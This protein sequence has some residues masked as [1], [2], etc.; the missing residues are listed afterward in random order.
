MAG[1][2][3]II[4]AYNLNP[5]RISS[6]LSFEIG[7][8][9][10]ARIVSA[11]DLGEGLILRLRDGWQFSAKLQSQLDFI[12]EGLV[13]FQVEDFQDGKLQLKIV[14]SKREDTAK[15]S[16]DNLLTSESLGVDKEDYEVLKKMIIHNMPLTKE[17]ISKVKTLIQFKSKIMQDNSS[18][19]GF[20]DSYLRS[21]DIDINSNEGKEME[22]RLRGFFKELKGINIDELLTMMEN[23]IDLTEEN[24]KSFLKTFKGEAVLYKK[25]IELDGIKEQNSLEDAF[26]IKDKLSDAVK[27]E[28]ESKIE[29]MKNIIKVLLNEK[30]KL[31]DNISDSTDFKIFNTI[32]NEYYLMDIPMNILDKKYNF[33]L[34]IK[35]ERSKGKKIDSKDVSLAVSLKTN[36]IGIVDAYIK[37]KDSNMHVN[38]KSEKSWFNALS[39]D[40]D[41]ILRELS[42]LGYNAFI[43][44]EEK[45][46]EM[47][48]VN[49]R[50]FF[51]DSRLESI[52]IRV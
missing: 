41:N 47:N 45:K 9:F 28:I 13:K 14:D 10:S 43:S 48:L 40:K 51:E 38:F 29:V 37:V 16:L 23:N 1:I 18:E 30:T 42:E 22:K 31:Q 21:K 5:K 32:S 49:C 3:N 26:E 2:N 8:V 17:N 52:D 34:I 19:E 36:N 6:K 20:I 27:K 24:L 35:D 12:P 46:T 25:L 39:K 11:D 4:G 33:K 44:I 7:Q 50:E 15:D